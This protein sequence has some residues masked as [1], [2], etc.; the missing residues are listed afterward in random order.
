MF[1]KFSDASMAGVII[2]TT[3]LFGRKS[4]P[5]LLK[6]IQSQEESD[7]EMLRGGERFIYPLKFDP[8]VIDYIFDEIRY[9][10]MGK[11]LPQC[12]TSICLLRDEKLA[13]M[14]GRLSASVR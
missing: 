12:V 14:F 3:Q 9:K 11:K 13:M 1:S 5:I 7:A 8:I 6:C 4:T 2:R 10:K